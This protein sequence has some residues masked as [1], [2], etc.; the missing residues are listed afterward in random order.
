MTYL[1]KTRQYMK[2]YNRDKYFIISDYVKD[3]TIEEDN[4]DRAIKKYAE[5]LETYGTY[6]SKNAI[7]TKETMYDEKNNPCGYVFTAHGDFRDDTKYRWTKQYFEVYAHI[8]EIQNAI[9]GKA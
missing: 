6:V 7:N 3:I 2:D 1:F 5:E 4:L 9:T 8:Y